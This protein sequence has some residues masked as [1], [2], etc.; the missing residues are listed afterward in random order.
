M[1]KNKI[2]T[3][4]KLTVCALLLVLLAGCGASKEDA[5]GSAEEY[6]LEMDSLKQAGLGAMSLL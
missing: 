1:K 4:V 3:T 6:A 5:G 2:G